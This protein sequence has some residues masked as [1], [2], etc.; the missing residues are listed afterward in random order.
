MRRKRET[1]VGSLLELLARGCGGLHTRLLA[2]VD[3]R[4]HALNN[5]SSDGHRPDRDDREQ[6]CQ[7]DVVLDGQITCLR[8]QQ[9]GVLV[10]CLSFRSSGIPHNMT[11][12][13]CDYSSSF[14]TIARYSSF[15][16][17]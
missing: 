7:Q 9:A 16:L 1:L 10:H 17:N 8:V 11:C 6:G 5:A 4:L 13:F 15:S 12:N 3:K 14:A 2:S